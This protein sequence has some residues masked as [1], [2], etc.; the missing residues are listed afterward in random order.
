V[1]VRA[2]SGQREFR[3][4][5]SS[6]DFAAAEWPIAGRCSPRPILVT[7]YPTAHMQMVGPFVR[8]RWQGLGRR[9]C[10]AGMRLGGPPRAGLKATKPFL[11]K[12]PS[13]HLANC[14]NDCRHDE[15]ACR[16]NEA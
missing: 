12:Q 3:G 16:W 10:L 4:R 6:T 8:R 2:T 15:N 14:K 5:R 13:Q 7:S 11:A 1:V 9:Y